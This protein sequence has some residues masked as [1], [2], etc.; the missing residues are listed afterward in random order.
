MKT[1]RKVLVLAAVLFAAVIALAGWY[2]HHHLIPVLQPAGEVGDKERNLMIFTVTL[3]LVVVIPVFVMLGTFAWRYR[4]GNPHGRYSPE[5]EGNRMLETIWWLIPA[6]LIAII[7]TIT[8]RSSYALD[9]FRPL[10][11]GK[12]EHIEVV[13]LDWKWLFIYPDQHVAS[14]NVAYI[15]VGTPVEFDITSDTVMTSFWVP[16]LGGQMYAMPG[17][18]T[19]LNLRA[20][21]PGQYHGVAA[22]IS[23]KGFAD[24]TFTVSA[25]Q[26][27]LLPQSVRAMRASTGNLT[28]SS[29]AALARPSVMKAGAVAYYGSADPNLYDTIVMKYMMP[30]NGRASVD[31]AN[32]GVSF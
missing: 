8:W 17:M 22:N 30:S 32:L 25:V 12:T 20:D 29:Y 9:P 26:P 7:G 2:L 28:S 1:W 3:S 24:Q 18:I 13:A 15:P 19:K 21:K 16:Q 27:Q 31:A 11:S 10:S 23:G 5:L 4:E 14:V 6:A